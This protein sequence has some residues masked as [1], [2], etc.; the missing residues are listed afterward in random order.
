MSSVKRATDI[1]LV[2]EEAAST[3]D[4]GACE[5]AAYD[6]NGVRQE[7]GNLL[8][9]VHDRRRAAIDNTYDPTLSL[10]DRKG[11]VGFVDGH[12]EYVPRKEAHFEPNI[13]PSVPIN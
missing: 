12:A 13:N 10:P 4:D 6:K 9:I 11:N 8:N 3:I 1:V 5:M 2:I 7:G